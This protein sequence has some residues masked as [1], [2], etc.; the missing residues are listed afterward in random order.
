MGILGWASKDGT[1]FTW[2]GSEQSEG[3]KEVLRTQLSKIVL[4]MVG[5]VIAFP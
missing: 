2:R 5:E 3:E 1:T 4:E